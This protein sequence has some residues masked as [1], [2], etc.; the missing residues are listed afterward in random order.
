LEGIAAHQQPA[1]QVANHHNGQRVQPGQPGYNDGGKAIARREVFLQAM[2]H[3]AQFAGTG[4]PGQPAGNNH[5]DD[6]I[7]GQ[8]EAGIA[9]GVGVIAHQLQLKTPFTVLEN[10]PHN[11]RGYHCQKKAQVGGHPPKDGDGIAK[12]GQA[13]PPGRFGKGSGQPKA[14]RRPGAV[15]KILLN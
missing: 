1:K 12:I 11:H 10:G 15:N 14:A 4:Q 2:H 3:P 7:A 6:N 9:G 5:G 13:G 8:I